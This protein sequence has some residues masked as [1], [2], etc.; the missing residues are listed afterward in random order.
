MVERSVSVSTRSTPNPAS[1]IS[2][3]RLAVVVLGLVV[4]VQAV[5]IGYQYVDSLSTEAPVVMI[6]GPGLAPPAALLPSPPASVAPE[7]AAE[8]ESVTT[9]RVVPGA[10]QVGGMTLTA[11]IDLQVFKDGELVGST[12][13][14]IAM[15]AGTHTVEVTN[16]TLG[17][18]AQQRV[19]VQPG[20]MAA[21]TVALPEGR[22]SINAAPWAEVL[23]DGVAA[24]ETP[25]ANLS[26]TIGEHEII[27]RHP[28]FDEQ[29]Q[30][31]VVNVDGV[32]RVSAV[33]RQ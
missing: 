5:V 11:A 12:G 15:A 6:A 17:Y 4:V 1:R 22:L 18:R 28:Q 9:D 14:P 8:P 32:T 31:A 27:F 25:L 29:R 13:S 16:E 20:Q 33:F 26:L 19:V 2:S 24:G 30:T 7:P 23:I 3:S 21:I 10:A